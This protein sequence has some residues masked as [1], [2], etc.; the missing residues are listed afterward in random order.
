MTGRPTTTPTKDTL[1]VWLDV[2]LLSRP[3]LVGL[4]SHERGHIRFRYDSA[5][6]RHPARFML[7]PDLSLDGQ[8]FFPNPRQANFGI[9][10]DSSPD[11]WGQT[12]M[13]RREAL[14]ASDEGRRPRPLHA[15]DYLIGVQ[16]L[17]RQGALRFRFPGTETFLDAQ[18]R[19]APPVTTLPELQAVALELTRQRIDNLDH[20]RR[21]LAVL[22]APG[23]SL[24]GA[25]P[26]ANF[27]DR[28]GSFWIGKFPSRTDTQDV[29]AWEMLTHTLARRA[30]LDVPEARLVRLGS[31]HHTFCVERFDR[32]AGRR[33]FFASALTM[34]G[35]QQGEGASYLDL[36][37]FLTSHGE[38]EFLAADLAQLFRRV[39]FNVAV[40]NRD[41]HLR[42]HG[43]VL[44]HGGW[45]PSPAFDLNPSP[46]QAEHVLAIDDADTRP[47]V[48][49]AL[50][51]AEFYR[52]T[53]ARA[54]T[55]VDD[56]LRVVRGW[57]VVAR[58]L[59]ISAADIQLAEAA[60][61]AAD[62]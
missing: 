46:G 56:V 36:A 29:A 22:V 1:E 25:R 5:W 38:P 35:K 41:D 20:L 50:A 6:L 21:W 16:D 10:L 27:V 59:G 33:R 62:E 4:L 32:E 2:N 49:T 57:H 55:I 61:V 30:Q 54:R 7:D 53:P 9:F 12:L 42:N 13:D 24:G 19:A 47:S 26:K 37:L 23:A 18:L 34:T 48:M 28:D 45:R 31:G 51:T 60:F 8:V 58:R 17:T 44:G 14:L 43:F 3:N 40:G 52:L 39:V 15:W 11:R